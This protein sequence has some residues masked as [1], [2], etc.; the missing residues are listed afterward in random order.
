M[1]DLKKGFPHNFPMAY[2]KNRNDSIIVSIKYG[3]WVANASS[4][5]EEEAKL[6]IL[7]HRIVQMYLD[8]HPEQAKKYL[9]GEINVIDVQNIFIDAGMWPTAV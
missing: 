8:S 6:A 9:N 1:V 2:H 4:L 3:L 5:S 7:K